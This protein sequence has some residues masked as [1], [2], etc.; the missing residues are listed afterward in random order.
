MRMNYLV[1]VNKNKKIPDDYDISNHLVKIQN[2]YDKDHYYLIE[3]NAYKMFEELRSDLL[4]NDNIRIELT[5]AYRSIERQQ[6]IWNQFLELYGEE[7]NKT[8]VA[9][10]GYSEHH[11]GLCLDIGVVINDE[12]IDD[13]KLYDYDDINRVIISKLSKYGFILRYPEGKEDKTG[14]K[15]ETWH[16]RYLNDIEI[17]KYIMDHNLCLE[18]YLEERCD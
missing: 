7:Y 16:F 10:P 4:K 13:I 12:L 17:A 18:E 14:Y 8:H 11:T 15:Y 6:D 2:H 3:E 9:V 1:L 5:S